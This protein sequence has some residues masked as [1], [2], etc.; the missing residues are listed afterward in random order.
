MTVIMERR[1]RHL[2]A[3]QR[4]R[5]HEIRAGKHWVARIARVDGRP[6]AQRFSLPAGFAARP[7]AGSGMTHP[8]LPHQCFLNR[9]VCEAAQR[10]C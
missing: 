9:L 2:F 3:D 8:L 4:Y 6:L 7:K 5:V 10:M 1:L